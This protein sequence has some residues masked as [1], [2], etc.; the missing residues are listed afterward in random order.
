VSGQSTVETVEST[1]IEIIPAPVQHVMPL[2]HQMDNVGFGQSSY[3]N[4]GYGG[5]RLINEYNNALAQWA[6]AVSAAIQ[7]WAAHEFGAGLGDMTGGQQ[8]ANTHA[9]VAHGTDSSGSGSGYASNAD[10]TGSQNQTATPAKDDATTSQKSTGGK[11][12]TTTD[13]SGATTNTPHQAAGEKV[14]NNPAPQ[15]VAIQSVFSDT[16]LTTTAKQSLKDA[17]LADATPANL[18]DARERS[19]KPQELSSPL[20]NDLRNDTISLTANRREASN[21]ERIGR[22]VIVPVESSAMRSLLHT[23]RHDNSAEEMPGRQFVPMQYDAADLAAMQQEDQ[24]QFTW[25][26][27]AALVGTGVLIGSYAIAVQRRRKMLMAAWQGIQTER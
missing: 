9:P 13:N 5:M 14:A 6:A 17:A 19:N 27:F 3:P 7:S 23:N 11:T 24:G 10:P 2:H 8:N 20:L 1:T 26:Q 25:K 12:S 16:H 21:V 15:A 18:K 22:R 4:F